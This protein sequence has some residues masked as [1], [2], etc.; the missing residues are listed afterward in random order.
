MATA[1]SREFLI[2]EI[3]VVIFSFIIRVFVYFRVS[4]NYDKGFSKF[5]EKVSLHT[6]TLL[7]R[8]YVT[9]EKKK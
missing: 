9:G 2:G 7:R 6:I 1:E 4:K 8:E 5:S 3:H